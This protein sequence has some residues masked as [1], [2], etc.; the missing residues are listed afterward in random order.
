MVDIMSKYIIYT[1]ISY[2]GGH[3]IHTFNY[4]MFFLLMTMFVQQHRIGQ[5]T[6]KSCVVWV[7]IYI[8]FILYRVNINKNISSSR[9]VHNEN[10]YFRLIIFWSY[11]IWFLKR[12][13]VWTN[14][15]CLY[16]FS[17]SI[18]LAKNWYLQINDHE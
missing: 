12:A 13:S 3:V 7:Y 9:T 5:W 1:I 15:F 17:Q 14:N 6:R 10:Q 8:Y 18:F 16:S 2:V 11:H 4:A